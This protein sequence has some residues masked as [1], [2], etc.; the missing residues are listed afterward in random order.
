MASSVIRNDQVAPSS[1]RV[2]PSLWMMMGSSSW[3]GPGSKLGS[4]LP[5]S[6]RVSWNRPSLTLIVYGVTI[7]ES[8][9]KL[10]IAGILPGLV[11]AAMFMG[12]VAIY[13]Q[14]SKNYNPKEEPRLSLAEKLRLSRFLIPVLMLIALVIGSMYLG[15]ATAT[16]AAAF[17]VIGA[18][19]LLE[20]MLVT[21][22]PAL[23]G[24][25][26]FNPFHHYRI[27]EILVHDAGAG[28]GP[29]V[30][31][32]M[33]IALSALATAAFSRRDVPA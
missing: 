25:S 18:L 15:F 16:E 1:S 8:I 20:E 7:N 13:S 10:F 29:W 4:T 19:F 24:S 33:F 2:L 28:H 3:G 31:L 14:V 9:S 11:L 26:A 12:Y 6:S 5:A 32:A 23:K 22:V 17:G 30:L 27:A 21:L